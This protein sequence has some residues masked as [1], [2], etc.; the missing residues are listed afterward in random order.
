[1]M[2]RLPDLLEDPQLTARDAYRR[3]THELL[4]AGL[5]AATRVARFRHIPDPPL[6][7]APLAGQ[8]SRQICAEVLGLDDDDIEKLIASGVLQVAVPLDASVRPGRP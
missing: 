2:H 8:Q 4:P 7:Q 3:L 5:P 1:M 6:R